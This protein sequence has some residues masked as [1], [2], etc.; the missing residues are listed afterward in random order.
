MMSNE[1]ATINLNS[2][3][4][5]QLS[6]LNMQIVAKIVQEANANAAEALQL[7]R[8][9]Q[10]ELE[11]AK[12]EQKKQLELEIARHRV[13]ESKFGFVALT[14]LG[15]KYQV[16]IGPK[17]LGKLLRV[18]GICQPKSNQTIPFRRMIDE[19]F[20]Q[21]DDRYDGYGR[22][23]FKYNPDK[24]IK[25]VDRWLTDRG[26]LDE[27]YSATNEKERAEFIGRLFVNYVG[28]DE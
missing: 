3:T 14:D 7:S 24:C 20:A 12:L 6:A 16:S 1:L 18:V 19:G 2:L 10:I 21:T 25:K 5:E 13:T 22:T 8:A 15:L 27:F 17:V 9:N 4:V 28:S 11:Q 26:H 23:N